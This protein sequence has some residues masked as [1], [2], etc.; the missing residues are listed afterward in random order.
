MTVRTRV[1]LSASLVA[2]VAAW[3]VLNAFAYSVAPLF[4]VS[5]GSTADFFG[6]FVLPGAATPM[7][8]WAGRA[9]F[10]VAALGWSLVYRGVGR[11]LPGG[12]WFR[13]L[14]FGA[15]IWLVSALLLPLFVVIH[16]AGGRI[17]YPGLMGL[18]WRGASGV[19]LSV[20]AHIAFGMTL[21]AVTSIQ[22]RK[23]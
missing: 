9:V 18:G 17:D 4:G 3:L 7:R 16:P 13:G 14:L 1:S 19:A 11:Y 10:L 6:S 20:L 2:G 5:F 22:E 15:G 12:S 23:A 8:L 21:G